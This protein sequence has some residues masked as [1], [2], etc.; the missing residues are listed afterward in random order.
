MEALAAWAAASW[1]ALPA[2]MLAGAPLICVLAYVIYGLTGFGST[3][4]SAPLYVH[5]LPLRMIVPLQSLLD[6]TATLLLGSKAWRK[7]RWREVLTIAPFMMLGVVAGVTLLV[8]VAER[9]LILGFG[10][11]VLYNGAQGLRPG[12]IARKFGR[13]WAAPLGVATGAAG[14]IFGAGGPIIVVYLASRI[15]D[16][17]EMRASIMAT[18]FINSGGRFTV[19]LLA[20][21][22]AQPGLLFLAVWLLPWMAL[23][24]WLG[25]RLHKRLPTAQIRR[26][27][28]LILI[29]AGISLILRSLGSA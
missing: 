5:L 20:G 15:E 28:Y 29:L 19:F 3:L 9:W 2:A 22:F 12:Q 24:L 27:I 7:V 11:F 4:L 16:K 21:L 18:I 14:A 1:A 8:Y 26:A 17:E 13:V 6:L 10:L 23:G 25:N